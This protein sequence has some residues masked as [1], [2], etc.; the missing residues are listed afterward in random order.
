MVDN[1]VLLGCDKAS[2]HSNGAQKKSLLE[3]HHK[4]ILTNRAHTARKRT[5]INKIGKATHGK[6]QHLQQCVNES[7]TDYH[8]LKR[9]R[10]GTSFLDPSQEATVCISY[11]YCLI[12][13]LYFDMCYNS[14][15]Q[16][17]QWMLKNSIHFYKLG[18]GNTIK[19]LLKENKTQ[20][21]SLYTSQR[22][23]K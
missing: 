18:C 13:C 10:K 23:V 5:Y 9:K 14:V 3:I 1:F 19:H 2:S 4:P 22:F 7:T 17:I 15:V 20:C 8:P 12:L 11:L 21:Y 6:P 16:W